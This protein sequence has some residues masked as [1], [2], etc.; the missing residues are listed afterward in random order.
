MKWQFDKVTHTQE[1][2]SNKTFPQ[3]LI[4]ISTL[5][6]PQD[7]VIIPDFKPNVQNG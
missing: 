3:A 2:E 7:L 5:H 6:L 4:L 1:C